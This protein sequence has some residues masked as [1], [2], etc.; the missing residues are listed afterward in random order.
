M[1][2]RTIWPKIPPP[3][4]AH[5]HPNGLLVGERNAWHRLLHSSCNGHGAVE[6][7]NDDGALDTGLGLHG[8][9]VAA[10][11]AVMAPI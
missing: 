1:L 6:G 7:N 8:V 3:V 10:E 4:A 11:Q 9:D 5:L 2:S